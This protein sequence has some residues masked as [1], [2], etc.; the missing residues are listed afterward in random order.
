MSFALGRKKEWSMPSTRGLVGRLG[1]SLAV[2]TSVAMALAATSC[3]GGGGAGFAAKPMVLVE[4]LFTDRSLTPA[5]PTGVKGLPRNA[6]LVF[7]FSEQVDAASV[8]D[9]TIAIRFG[10]QFQSVPKGA[11]QVAG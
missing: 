11:F 6:E 8:N 1:S 9:Q 4:F 10:N 2:A 5:F 7:D 3:G